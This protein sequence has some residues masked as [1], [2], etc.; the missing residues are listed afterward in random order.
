MDFPESSFDAV[1]DKATLDSVLVLYSWY[2][3]GK[4]QVPMPTKWFQKYIE[5]WAKMEFIWSYHMVNLNS[6][7]ATLKNLN[8]SGVWKYSKWLNQP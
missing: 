2:S 5:F 4:T 6:D 8:M 7:W 3:V 1:V